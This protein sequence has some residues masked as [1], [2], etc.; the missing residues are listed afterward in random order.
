MQR[1]NIHKHEYLIFSFRISHFCLRHTGIAEDIVYFMCG[2]Y[3]DDFRIFDD[4]SIIFVSE[5]S[6][7]KKKFEY[8]EYNRD[9]RRFYMEKAGAYREGDLEYLD[10]LLEKKVK[11][12]G[13]DIDTELTKENLDAAFGD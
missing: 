4:D 10:K 12:T 13:D 8:Y 2:T 3:C 9:I 6:N 7:P 5:Y 1:R 11:L